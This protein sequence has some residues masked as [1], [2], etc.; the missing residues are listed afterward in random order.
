VPGVVAPPSP[1]VG[2]V[3]ATRTSVDAILDYATNLGEAMA[4]LHRLDVDIVV[5]A[6]DGWSVRRLGPSR[7]AERRARS[8]DEAL[9]HVDA[10]ILHYNPFSWGR[11]GFAPDL[12]PM[13]ARLRRR[14][15]RVV[16]GILAHERYVDM[17][18][19][20]W[21]L[22]GGWQR[23]Q[24]L[25]V[26]RFADVAWSSI[27]AWTESLRAQTRGRV[28]Q[29]PISSNLPD[30]RGARLATRER[31]GIDGSRLVV[32]AFG[33][34]HPSRLMGH[35]EGAVDAIAASGR[36]V[37]LLNLGAGAPPV[38]VRVA[39]VTV[40]APGRLDASAVAEHL[41]AA[42]L[43]LAPFV[44]GVSARRTTL[45]AAMQHGLPIVGTDGPLTDTAM[46]DAREALVLTPSVDLTGFVAAV[47][48]LA[49]K[50][51]QRARRGA[52]ARRLYE[53]RFDWPVACRVALSG[54]TGSG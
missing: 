29:I 17:H 46:R 42:D 32:A 28:A 41:A 10:L 26:L 34:D 24:F 30:R 47:R 18:G 6:R 53:A 8:L 33:T 31:L 49:A 43:Y 44:D 2:M 36:P 14:R 4:T 22:M 25:A 20:R 19:L 12:V 35:I 50:P 15:P 45:M 5:R 52:A 37:T 9:A 11:R 40:L 16:I 21:T 1:R 3:C 39:D 54:L 23:V 48:A 13:L 27:E 38:T 7:G 51:E